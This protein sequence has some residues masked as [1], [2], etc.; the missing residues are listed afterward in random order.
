M[1]DGI[2]I[3]DPK[4]ERMEIRFSIDEFYGG[5]HCGECLDVYINGNWQ[6]A[7]IEFNHSDKD[8]Y[9]VG[10]SKDISLEGLPARI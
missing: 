4:Q 1:R 2:L 10:I 3:Y 6:P 5:L 9:L 8:W 7:R